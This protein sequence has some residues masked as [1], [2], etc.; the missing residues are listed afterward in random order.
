VTLSKSTT[1]AKMPYHYGWSLQREKN[2]DKT[3]R[4]LNRLYAKQTNPNKKT[5]IIPFY[6]VVMPHLLKPKRKKKS[7]KHN[8][9][10]WI[11]IESLY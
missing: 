9:E 4:I 3:L 2:A 5:V 7:I 8:P 11:L 6:M 1:E 10:A